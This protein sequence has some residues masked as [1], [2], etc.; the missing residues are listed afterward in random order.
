MSPIPTFAGVSDDSRFIAI[1]QTTPAAKN[2]PRLALVDACLADK[3]AGFPWKTS[4]TGHVF[5]QTWD[6]AIGFQF[7][8]TLGAVALN[9]H[10]TGDPSCW[11]AN[12]DRLDCRV[13][14]LVRHKPAAFVPAGSTFNTTEQFLTALHQLAPQLEALSQQYR[15]GRRPERLSNQQV[16]DFLNEV[17][18]NDAGLFT[19]KTMKSVHDYLKG[20]LGVTLAH[21]QAVSILR[22]KQQ[23][24][25]DMKEQYQKI[26]ELFPTRKAKRFAR[27]GLN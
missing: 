22:G 26:A 27:L 2:V 10:R 25:P 20:H 5:R 14:N 4:P 3:L 6:R 23:Y 13:S 12:G 9:I 8:D 1:N 16:R 19:G 17:A 24:Q 18:E 15:K 11:P 21:Y 7:T